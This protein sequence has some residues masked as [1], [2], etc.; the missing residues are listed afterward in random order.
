M[1]QSIKLSIILPTYKERE[2]LT[3][4]IPQILREFQ[5]ESIEIIVVD[6]HSMDGTRELMEEL[7]AL[8]PNVILL[9]RAGLFG[10]GSALRDGYNRAQG[11]YILS[12]DADCSFS[13]SD[14]RKLYERI[15]TGSDLVLGFRVDA[16]APHERRFGLQAFHSWCENRVISPLSNGV[17]GLI[18]GIGLKNYNTNF[19]ILR[20]SLWKRLH[21]IEDRQFFLFETIV[22][23]KQAGAVIEELPV[24]FAPRLAG[25]SKVSFLRQA[26]LYFLK[27]LRVA[28]VS[29]K[30]A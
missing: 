25:E 30:R 7:Y 10:I 23:A 15:Q 6:D 24:A 21:T 5:N 13:T 26:P 17:I 1:E 11:E 22:R 16:I 18:S 27:L 20:A 3:V 28:Y 19:R 29:K 2:N 8:H 12:S 4:F 9:E 14:M